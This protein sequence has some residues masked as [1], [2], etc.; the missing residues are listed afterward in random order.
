MNATVK[1]RRTKVINTKKMSVVVVNA[2]LAVE[3]LIL[4]FSLLSIKFYLILF[5]F[6]VVG[7]IQFFIVL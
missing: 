7:F 1:Q 2:L 5:L 3:I 6:L 4:Y